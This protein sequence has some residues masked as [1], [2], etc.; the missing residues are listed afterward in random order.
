MKVIYG[1]EG[2]TNKVKIAPW[3]RKQPN[4]EVLNYTKGVKY[5]EAE[6]GKYLYA[7]REGKYIE[8]RQYVSIKIS[9]AHYVT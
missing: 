8:G 9:V 5:P 4:L 1:I 3:K 2:Y 7:V 6:V